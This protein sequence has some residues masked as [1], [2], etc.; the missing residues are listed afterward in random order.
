MVDG[1]GR[2]NSDSSRRA[3]EVVRIVDC[4][5]RELGAVG[6]ADADADQ[7]LREQHCVRAASRRDASRRRRSARSSRRSCGRSDRCRRSRRSAPARRPGVIV[8]PCDWT[9]HVT[10]RAAVRAE[11]R[12]EGVRGVERAA[13]VERI[14]KPCVVLRPVRRARAERDSASVVKTC[15][16]GDAAGRDQTYEHASKL[17]HHVPTWEQQTCHETYRELRPLRATQVG[18]AAPPCRVR[19]SP[20][21]WFT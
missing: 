15:H 11:R 17:P 8:Q 7:A 5:Q 18:V 12:E 6:N 16:V 21:D 19:L 9:W 2:R 14:A 1:S 4:V 20:A 13:R 10:Q 3:R